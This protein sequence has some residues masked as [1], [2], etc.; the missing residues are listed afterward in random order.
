MKQKSETKDKPIIKKFLTQS[1]LLVKLS[2][3]ANLFHTPDNQ[4]Y[5]NIPI[6]EHK[7]TWSIITR[8]FRRWLSYEF[9][10]KETK[11]PGR[12]AFKDALNILEAKGQ[13]DSPQQPIFIKL[14]QMNEKIYID[15]VNENWEVVEVSKDGWK[16]IKDPPIK[17]RRNRGMNPLPYP[18]PDG[19]LND[20][21][22]LTNITNDND[23]ILYV[24]CLVGMLQPKGPYPILV[25]QGVQGSAKSFI[26]R[27]TRSII[28]PSIVP[29]RTIPREERDLIIAANN[30]WIIN[31]DN[32]STLS[33]WLSDA[34]CRISTGGGLSKRGN[35]TDDQEIL[36]DVMRPIILNG[37]DNVI[38]RHDLAD[39][40]II[41]NLPLI[42]EEKRKPESTIRQ[43]FNRILPDILGAL[44]NAVSEALKNLP[45][46]KLSIFPRMA[47]FFMWVTAA[48]PALPWSVG[49]FMEAYIN[50]RN[51]TIG[52]A[53][54]SDP[55]AH[56][57]CNLIEK[58]D[59]W[60]GTASQLLN[61][62]EKNI[63]KPIQRT[64][65]WPKRSNILSTRLKRVATFLR[66]VNI[67]IE[68]KRQSHT[69]KRYIFIK[70]INSS[71]GDAGD[72][73]MISL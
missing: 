63:S 23:W 67:E 25:F 57:T 8:E 47:D 39:R 58:C 37:I 59:E 1:Q 2:E 5:A 44:C 43:E 24:S 61:E 19:S 29:L 65:S 51:E 22:S 49:K 27:I 56:A 10:K 26:S 20:L 50:N 71:K 46:I 41:I 36:F 32:I 30:S 53:I 69:G 70:R 4:T 35:Y 45:Y 60:R 34:L 42:T 16:I 13:Y 18:S 3:T 54:D 72:D 52:L 17:F 6:N 40:S 11:P 15:L 68:F 73:E 38:T 28:D 62:L 21:R 12:Q 55:V 33:N 64:K 9:Y 31:F 48:E 7:E 14:A 66:A